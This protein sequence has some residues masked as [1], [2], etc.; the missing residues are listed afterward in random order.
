MPKLLDLPKAD[1]KEKT[2]A[3]ARLVYAAMEPA[4]DAVCLAESTVNSR[5]YRGMCECGVVE[6]QECYGD[7][8]SAERQQ[9]IDELL[10]KSPDDRPF[11]ARTVQGILGE[12]TE[13]SA[14]N[15]EKPDKKDRAAMD[16]HPVQLSL[17]H[18]INSSQDSR[19]VSWRTV[20]VLGL[21][22]IAAIAVVIVYSIQ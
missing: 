12:L 5:F 19:D 9:L 15:D 22:I 17:I 7:A 20:A 4:D 10:A 21:G 2:R 11:N 16:V 13:R 1:R 6:D 3:I 18:R 8:F 14:T